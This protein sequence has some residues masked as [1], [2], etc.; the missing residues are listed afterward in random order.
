MTMT[1][2]PVNPKPEDPDRYIVASR[3]DLARAYAAMAASDDAAKYDIDVRILYAIQSVGHS[4]GGLLSLTL[5]EHDQLTEWE[6]RVEERRRHLSRGRLS[7]R[8][9]RRPMDLRR[10]RPADGTGGR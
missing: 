7:A 9:I 2:H 1:D 8:L 5:A 3:M 4:L 10:P 6:K